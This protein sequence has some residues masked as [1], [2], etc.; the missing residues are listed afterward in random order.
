MSESRDNSPRERHLDEIIAQYL[1]AREKGLAPARDEWIARHPEFANELRAFFADE[2]RLRS[3][4]GT[5]TK[6]D[7]GV[8]Q[9]DVTADGDFVGLMAAGLPRLRPAKAR[10][11]EIVKGDIFADQFRIKAIKDG[12]MGRVYI[13]DY[14]PTT[15]GAAAGQVAIKTVVDYDEWQATRAARGV[16]ADHEEYSRILVR[17]SREAETWVRLGKQDNIIWAFQ[18]ME[19]GDK[20]YIVMECADHGDLRSWISDGRLN[21]PLSVNFA[22]QFCRGMQQASFDSGLVHRDIK[23]ANVLITANQLLKI[24]DFGL[25]KAWYFA[26]ERTLQGKLVPLD[27]R[28]SE[29]GWGT[30][31]YMAPE[32]M[33]SL[34][35]AT[36]RSDV[37]SFGVMLFEMLTRQRLFIGTTQEEQVLQR[38]QPAPNARRVNPDVP[39]ALANVVERC[40]AFRPEDRFQS[41]YE[42]EEALQA[43]CGVLPDRMPIPDVS[44]LPTNQQIVQESYSLLSLHQWEKAARRAQDG[45]NSYPE[46]ADHWINKGKAL[47]ELRDFHGSERSFQRATELRPANALA[48][49]NLGFARLNLNNPQ[50]GLEATLSAI[51][52]DDELYEAWHCRGEC[53]LAMNQPVDATESLRRAISLRPHDWRAY[54]TLGRALGQ[55]HRTTEAADV[56][57]RAVKIIPDNVELWLL[58]AVA[59]GSHR[60]RLA[61][62]RQAV[63]RALKLDPSS[64][65]AW[66]VRASLLWDIEGP[67]PAVREHVS[68]CLAL[69]P[70]NP[71]GRHLLAMLQSSAGNR[72]M[73]AR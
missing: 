7:I 71:R 42:V 51:R 62:A 70:Q 50:G 16:P 66:A 57:A 55:Q 46:N 54:G 48:W 14:V 60:Q 2:N 12:G 37:F 72:H 23:P 53:E 38:A 49:A 61:E 18:V 34:A 63:D 8:V 11:S 6:T 52:L 45:I 35:D 39:T 67:S 58:L 59:L 17:F 28:L 4:M 73:D 10:R 20:P 68:K 40:V 22:I 56:L 21:V 36:V 47:G 19:V 29:P 9:T 25:S 1:Q 24:S 69:D 30:L 32:Q 15:G 3:L 31:A 41:F 27:P 33:K 26:G 65:D 43:I 5:T 13:A 64:S 44:G